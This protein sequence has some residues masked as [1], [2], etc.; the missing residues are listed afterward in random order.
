MENKTQVIVVGGGP[1]GIS[2]AVTIARA[3]K[4]VIL[5]ERG[6]FC[7]SKNVFG[8]AVYTKPIKEIFPD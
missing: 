4:N 7:G 5:I 2:A 3:N 8:G 1:A 6:N